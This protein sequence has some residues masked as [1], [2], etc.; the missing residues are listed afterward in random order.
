MNTGGTYKLYMAYY[1]GSA[2][3]SSYTRIYGE[4]SGYNPTFRDFTI[5]GPAFEEYSEPSIVEE[6]ESETESESSDTESESE[7]AII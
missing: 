4:H 2:T 7:S 5:Y 3:G 1:A 6:S